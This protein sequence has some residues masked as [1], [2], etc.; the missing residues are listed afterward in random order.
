[1]NTDTVTELCILGAALTIFIGVVICV[2]R[3]NI[4]DQCTRE[5]EQHQQLLV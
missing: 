5:N 2:T 3:R 1:M 4:A